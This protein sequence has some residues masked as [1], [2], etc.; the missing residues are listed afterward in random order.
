LDQ[1]KPYSRDNSY[2]YYAI[3][4]PDE[5]ESPICKGCEGAMIICNTIGCLRY[6]EWF[7]KNWNDNICVKPKKVKE[8]KNVD[9][10]FR[11]EHPDLVR[12]GICFISEI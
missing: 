6:R 12:E 8:V 4:K 7:I 11:Y 9:G 5:T 1:T 10:F 2:W 3:K